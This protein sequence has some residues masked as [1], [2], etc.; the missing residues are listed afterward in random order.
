[1]SYDILKNR[2]TNGNAFV[3]QTAID[4]INALADTLEITQEQAEELLALAES[5]GVDVLPEDLSARLA[6][7]EAVSKK[8]DAFVEAAKSNP[9]L[10]EIF[11]GLEVEA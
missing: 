1:M 3:K 8:F 9:V 2:L 11:D 7:L 5:K 4:R 10:S 6:E